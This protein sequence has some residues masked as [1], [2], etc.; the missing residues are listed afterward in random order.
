M[1]L[2]ITIPI[3][4]VTGEGA[5]AGLLDEMTRIDSDIITN[6][7]D[8]GHTKI[9]NIYLSNPVAQATF[10]IDLVK[11]IVAV[12]G[13]INAFP[14]WFKMTKA[15]AE[16]TDVPTGV[17][18]RSYTDENDQE[19]IR[20]WSQWHDATHPV[21]E[22]DD[23]GTDTVVVSGNGFG[24]ELTG[25]EIVAATTGNDAD[26]TPMTGPEFVAYKAQFSAE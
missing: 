18:D 23:N 20:K 22:V 13:E 3:A 15:Y 8:A 12:G 24:V 2:E 1:K 5:F 14:V 17:P 9:S 7:T 11:Q 19:I 25:S 16:A 26:V 4:Q 21:Y 6:I 10:T